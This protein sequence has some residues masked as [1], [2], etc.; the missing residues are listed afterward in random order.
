M[1][2][3]YVE[4]IHAIMNQWRSELK[5]AELDVLYFINERT[6]RYNKF[7]EI[8]TINQF[9]DG[10]FTYS[11]ERIIA[12]LRRD[13]R[14]IVK[15]YHRLEELGLITIEKVVDKFKTL[16]KFAINCKTI[17]ER[18]HAMALKI[19]KKHKGVQN[20]T[21]EGGRITTG[22]RGVQ[23]LGGEA[24]N[25]SNNTYSKKT[26]K[27]TTD[28]RSTRDSVEE[29][30]QQT[31]DR[32]REKQHEK[33][34]KANTNFT[35]NNVLAL[36]K[37]CMNK[38]HTGCVVPNVTR[39]DYAVLRNSYN[40]NSIPIPLNEFIEWVIEN[41]QSLK[42]N[43]LNW[44]K[45]FPAVPSLRTLGY[46]YQYF[47]R[48]YGE[49]EA[50]RNKETARLKRAGAT[51]RVDKKRAE[52]SERKVKELENKLREAQTEKEHFRRMAT[53]N[54]RTRVRKAPSGTLKSHSELNF[55]DI[56]EL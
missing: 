40:A 6:V 14:T 36:W 8:I 41:W 4:S 11:G 37:E 42:D 29:V 44:V 15:A 33:A 30:I 18:A 12:G 55:E 50:R 27:K 17:I 34:M 46:L 22:G 38:H 3:L 21:K 45:D 16:N 28:T 9:T 20:D 49:L 13:R 19:G 35:M 7:E 52:E 5:P 48:A 2:S 32:Q 31:I 39:K 43:E 51:N 10:V 47:V 23:P 24:H 56:E 54:N 25:H 26:N 1:R 53:E